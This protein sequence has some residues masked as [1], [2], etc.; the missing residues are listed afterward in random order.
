MQ[1]PP[2]FAACS[3]LRLGAETSF[4]R[5]MAARGNVPCCM[6]KAGKSGK[7]AHGGGS[8]KRLRVPG[9]SPVPSSAA[10]STQSSSMPDIDEEADR[11]SL[12][13]DVAMFKARESKSAGNEEGEGIAAAA[14]SGV[15][16]GV[17][18][19]LDTA[20]VWNFFLIVALLGWLIVSL[21]PHFATKNEF[22][23]DPWLKLWVPFIQP[24]LGVQ[25]AG[26]IVQGMVTYA[27]S[28][29]E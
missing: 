2:A 16:A 25:M 29:E 1:L 17:K 8:A 15:Y 13:R 26:I 12:R 28:N 7:K 11:E 20:M 6:T 5:G 23:L 4:T 27:F 10:G 21:V 14:A 18:K 3:A 22:L 19:I 24:V 9:T